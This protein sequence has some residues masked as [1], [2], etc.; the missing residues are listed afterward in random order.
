MGSSVS[1]NED[2]TQNELLKK[3]VAKEPVPIGDLDF[4][5]YLLKYT[6]YMPTNR[7]SKSFWMGL[8]NYDFMI[9]STT[10]D[11]SLSPLSCPQ[12]SLN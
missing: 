4:W 1:R 5:D 2:F 12:N 9:P 7:Y 10:D 3:F 11:V 6:L 8:I